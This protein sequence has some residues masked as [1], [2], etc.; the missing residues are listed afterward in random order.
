MLEGVLERVSWG[1][2]EGVLW[3]VLEG[4][5]WGVYSTSKAPLCDT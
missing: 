1:V 4:V 3:G 5:L 2:L